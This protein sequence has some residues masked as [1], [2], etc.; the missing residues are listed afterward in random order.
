MLNIVH[1]LP[2]WAQVAVFV[3]MLNILML[4][5]LFV[6][7]RADFPATATWN[8]NTES[9]LAGYE[10]HRALLPC[11]ITGDIVS[12]TIVILGKVLTYSFIVPS[13]A[14]DVCV[15]LKAFDV[16]GNRSPYSA[17]VGKRVVAP[18]PVVA[19]TYTLKLIGS[20]V[21][22]GVE[23]ISTPVLPAGMQFDIYTDGVFERSEGGVPYCTAQ[24]AGTPPTC[25]ARAFALGV[26]TVE[27]RL[28]ASGVEISRKSVTFTAS[29]I[30]PPASPTGL[31][32]Q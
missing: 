13:P 9:D 15:Q 30:T 32:V 18:T 4:A 23:A 21:A 31:A 29:D 12:P 26:H 11:P 2:E 5:I 7:A 17:K 19:P 3:M 16:A 6:S 22:W 14:T 25:G 20:G 8:A 27:F 28:M 24:I 10:V 1:R